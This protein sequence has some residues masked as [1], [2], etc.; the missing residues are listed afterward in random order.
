[1]VDVRSAPGSVKVVI[2]GVKEISG[3]FEHLPED[4]RAAL[5]TEVTGLTAEVY[6]RARR[7]AGELLK[8]RSGRY[9]DSIVQK[10]RTSTA[11]VRGTVSAGVGYTA[12]GRK[13]KRVPGFLEF[14]GHA[15]ARMIPVRSAKALHFL[16]GGNEIF[17]ALVRHPG[18]T[19]APH[20]IIYGALAEMQSEIVSGLQR[21]TAGA[22]EASK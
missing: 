4:I 2:R 8:V 13:P 14:G 12:P 11:R 17:A 10:V 1:M 3:K 7:R 21:A 15:R 16:R 20:P 18:P 19:I 6:A 5:I 9:L 22:I